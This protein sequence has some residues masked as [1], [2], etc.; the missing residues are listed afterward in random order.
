MIKMPQH[1]GDCQGSQISNLLPFRQDNLASLLASTQHGGAAPLSGPSH[2][3]HAGPHASHFPARPLQLSC[4]WTAS[5]LPPSP[6]RCRSCAVLTST[7]WTGEITATLQQLHWLPAP[8]GF[9]LLPFS[10]IHV[11]APP[12]HRHTSSHRHILFLHPPVC[13]QLWDSLPLTCTAP[14][15]PI[16]SKLHF[17]LMCSDLQAVPPPLLCFHCVMFPLTSCCFMQCVCVS[18]K[19]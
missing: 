18:F 7:L 16:C 5:K 8:S 3:G 11:V 14:R 6:T 1:C 12:W 2:S 15:P 13:S 17:K 9:L 19:S 10:S 4:V